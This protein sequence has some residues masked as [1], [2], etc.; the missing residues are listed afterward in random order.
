[1][2]GEKKR[3]SEGWKRCPDISRCIEDWR[4][5]VV[6]PYFSMK[7]NSWAVSGQEKGSA[8]VRGSRGTRGEVN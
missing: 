8:E 6:D 5:Q 1:M 4:V 3:S 7:M 2:E